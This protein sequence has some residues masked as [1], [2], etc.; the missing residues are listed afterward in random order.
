M[1]FAQQVAALIQEW[2]AAPQ[3]QIETL[4]WSVSRQV[5]A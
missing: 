3:Q 1:I 5:T 4:V 2:K